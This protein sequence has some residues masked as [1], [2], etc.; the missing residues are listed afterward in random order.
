M[1][2]PVGLNASRILKCRSG[3]STVQPHPAPGPVR[4]MGD[5]DLSLGLFH[6]RATEDDAARRFTQLLPA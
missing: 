4:E 3:R 6:R 1:H 2:E 5:P